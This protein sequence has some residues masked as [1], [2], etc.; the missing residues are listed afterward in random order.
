MRSGEER[1]PWQDVA[2][3]AAPP[4]RGRDLAALT[5][6][7]RLAAP[8]S[9]LPG[10]ARSALETLAEIVAFDAISL[11]AWDPL[12]GRHRGVAALGLPDGAALAAP[13]EGRDLLL[14]DPGYRYVRARRAPHRRC[15]VPGARENPLIAEH[16]EPAGFAE[17]VTSCLFAPD[18][19][20]TGVLNLATR[21]SE[22]A[23]PETM[24][25]I[26]IA[27]EALA[28]LTDLLHGS[29]A[30]AEALDPS[31]AAAM[32]HADG[33]C[34][35]LPDRPPCPLLRPGAPVLAEAWRRRPRDHGAQAFLWHDGDVLWRVLAVRLGTAADGRGALLVAAAPTELPLSLRELEVLTA[36]TAGRPNPEIA[37]RLAISRHTVATHV[38]HVL[39]KLGVRSR[40]EAAAR[41]TRDGLVLGG[42]S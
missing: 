25:L 19:R 38:E 11:A 41:A 9:D 2:Q 21:T 20:Y 22:P 8:A 16:L 13:G 26:A 33:R 27:G 23:R 4:L 24:L 15:D 12:A 18:G 3:M 32:V 5:R 14:G 35:P 10:R 42:R 17:G 37:E 6:L 30:A 28:E 29:R 40:V 1:L 31:M 7:G 39:H 34:Q 36:M